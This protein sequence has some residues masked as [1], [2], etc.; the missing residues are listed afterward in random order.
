MD[1]PELKE[2][3]SEIAREMRAIYFENCEGNR[4]PLHLNTKKFA[5]SIGNHL[6]YEII[7]CTTNALGEHLLAMLLREEHANSK[8]ATILIADKNNECWSRLT[9]IK[10][11]CHLYI[12][13]ARI[14]HAEAEKVAVALLERGDKSGYYDSEVLAAFT[15]IEIMIPEHLRTWMTHEV[16]VEMKTPY[17]IAYT[18]KV[19]RKFVESKM[20]EWGITIH[21]DDTT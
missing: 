18:L 3:A 7:S 20:R 6:D 11:V 16:N 13:E 4:Q 9:H 2:K 1:I 5:N 17:Q 14:D 15:A 12:D 19:P 10:E 21:S 8:K